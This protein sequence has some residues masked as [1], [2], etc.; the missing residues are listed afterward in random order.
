M[1]AAADR[2]LMDVTVDLS[3]LDDLID[4]L[5]DEERVQVAKRI[6]KAITAGINWLHS[7][8]VADAPRDT[9]L[10][11]GSITKDDARRGF[12]RRVFAAGKDKPRDESGALRGFFQEF[13]TS[14]HP[15]QPFLLVHA[16]K[17]GDIVVSTLAAGDILER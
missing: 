10:L 5:G 12:S 4:D 3:E 17:A 9:G 2:V 8:A 14:R 1:D 6:N 15:P 13:G 11:A 7:T 16:E